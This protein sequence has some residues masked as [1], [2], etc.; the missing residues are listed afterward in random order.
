MIFPEIVTL[1]ITASFYDF[2]YF[3]VIAVKVHELFLNL[4][5]DP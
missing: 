1:F 3:P 4:I 5:D 2:R